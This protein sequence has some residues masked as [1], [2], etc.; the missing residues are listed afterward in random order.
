MDEARVAL[1]AAVKEA[2]DAGL[3]VIPPREDGSKAPEGYWGEFIQTRADIEILR[4]AY[5]TPR[6][7]IGLVTGRVSNNLEC[8]EFESETAYLSFKVAAALA[9][10][11]EVVERI[12]AGYLERAPRGGY[13]W[14]WFSELSGSGRKLA[15]VATGDPA[16]P[17]ETAIETRFEG[18]FIIVAPSHGPVHP[19]GKPYVR[20][21]GGFSSIYHISDED[22][23]ALFRVAENLDQCPRSDDGFAMFAPG[24]EAEG[25]GDRPGDDFIR[26]ARWHEDVLLPAGWTLVGSGVDREGRPQEFWR[27]PGKDQGNSAVLHP[28]SGPGGHGLFVPYST[29]TP[30]P[31]VQRGY[32]KFR[33][34]A[35][36][37]HDE[38]GDQRFKAARV[39]VETLGYKARE[40]AEEYEDYTWRAGWGW[41]RGAPSRPTMLRRS[42][43]ECLIYP[44]QAHSLVAPSEHLKSWLALHLVAEQA[45]A[46][47][48]SVYLD[49]EMDGFRIG[50][51]L[52]G[53]GLTDAQ[54]DL[55]H[56]H[57]VEDRAADGDIE[58]LIGMSPSVVVVD[59]LNELLA[60][61]GWD[62]TDTTQ[63]LKLFKA[64]TRPFMRE[65]IA[66]VTLDHPGNQ[67]SD[68]AVGSQA[69]KSGID[70][71]YRL[72][73]I[74]RGSPTTRGVSAI[75]IA[76]DRDGWVRSRAIGGLHAGKIV[77]D[78][79]PDGVIQTSI[80]AA[81][82]TDI[83][84]C[85]ECDRPFHG[86]GATCSDTCRQRRARRTRSTESD[87]GKL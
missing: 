71:V 3:C 24:V 85:S 7:G 47:Q 65:G 27:R 25:D 6:H 38:A 41:L 31:V 9:G 42:D 57:R 82:S 86:R 75:Q 78:P 53:M 21:N 79:Q 74:T 10:L 68:R 66:T 70:V 58:A 29:S 87:E 46:G 12:E 35:F 26:R 73:E 32:N 55:I 16:T 33:A 40:K 50:D 56:Y 36:L 8:C 64:V 43:G 84:T 22:R 52:R 67:Q 72:E 4:D 69:K 45:R 14:L 49:S 17:Y 81:F 23:Q 15:M 80:E 63:V 61:Y 20:V 30:F 18:Q 54:L 37:H 48:R 62:Y 2:Y 77:V 39:A 28:L 13:H 51:R 76:K 19:S 1:H 60:L 83:R 59:G 34:Y 11:D 44:G 5:R